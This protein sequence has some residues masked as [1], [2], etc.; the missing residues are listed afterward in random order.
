MRILFD[1]KNIQ[2]KDP[3]GTLVPGQEC[4]L[5]VHVPASV[6]AVAVRCLLRREDSGE[7]IAAKIARMQRD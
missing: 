2:H 6:G 5:C 3:F 7:E 4:T 1:S